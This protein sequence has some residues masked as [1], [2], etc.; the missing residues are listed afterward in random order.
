MTIQLDPMQDLG[1]Q[2]GQILDP[3]AHEAETEAEQRQPLRLDLPP[4]PFPHADN[5]RKA[6][7][8]YENL[9]DEWVE[10]NTNVLSVLDDYTRAAD[11]DRAAIEKAARDGADKPPTRKSA[12]KHKEA[13]EW[14]LAVCKAKREKVND[15]VR[16][17]AV[18]KALE[19]AHD[20]YLS[21]I[22]KNAEDVESILQGMLEDFRIRYN[23]ARSVGLRTQ[24]SLDWFSDL[25][26]KRYGITQGAAVF[27]PIPEPRL[28]SRADIS[29]GRIRAIAAVVRP[30]LPD[31]E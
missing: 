17:G 25:T 29:L 19:A 26:A 22:F 2:L 30:Q 20:W 31:S 12:D 27:D 8:V 7:A 1:Q 13:L 18:H 21:R 6:V 15:Y 16:S 24:H 11:A 9:R 14:A 4:V 3:L 10:A 5:V 23:E 28:P